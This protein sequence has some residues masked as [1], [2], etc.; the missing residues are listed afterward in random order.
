[1]TDIQALYARLV[2]KAEEELCQGCDEKPITD[3]WHSLCTEC[4][5]H[6]EQA[7]YDIEPTKINGDE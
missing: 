6:A 2:K 5:I 7:A 4:A 1:M 3:I